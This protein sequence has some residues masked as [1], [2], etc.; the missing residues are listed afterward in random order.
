MIYA[1][2]ALLGL[3]AI[4][5]LI[6]LWRGFIREVLDIT[7]WALA[8]FIA[9]QF[10]GPVATLL[11]EQISVP[12]ARTAVAFG[13][14]FLGVLILG[15]LITWLISKL[16]EKTGLT[17]SDRMLGGMFGLLRGVLL[18]IALVL[19]AGFTPLPQDPWWEHSQVIQA[20]LPLADWA[21]GF[22]PDSVREYFDLYRSAAAVSELQASVVTVIESPAA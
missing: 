8:F 15:G 3:V 14:L 16:V 9:F 20:V 22:L 5:L 21:A 2:W 13:G 7:V 1:D 11:D 19:V 18:V 4:S 6:G 10:A 17:G 12:S